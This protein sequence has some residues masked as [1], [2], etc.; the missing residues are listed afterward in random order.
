[1]TRLLIRGEVLVAAEAGRLE[2]ADAVAVADGRVVAVG[3]Y[4]DA[5]SVAG[6]DTRE[7]DV[8]GSAVVPGLHD[9]HIHLVGL[10]RTR[11][12]VVLDDAADGSEVKPHRGS[13][14]WN[15]F[16]KRWIS[17]WADGPVGLTRKLFRPLRSFVLLSFYEYPPV[18][19]AMNSQ[20][21]PSGAVGTPR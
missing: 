18:K 19:H 17:I 11:A 4:D 6:A 20:R 16:R 9:F 21:T 5:R 1:M 12:G 8:R 2:R 15:P 3:T 7:I 10:A 14:V 13:V